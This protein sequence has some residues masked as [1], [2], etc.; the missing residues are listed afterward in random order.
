MSK[1]TTLVSKKIAKID[2]ISCNLKL[3]N[4]SLRTINNIVKR[5]SNNIANECGNYYL[6]IYETEIQHYLILKALVALATL[7]LAVSQ[8]FSSPIA[9]PEAEAQ[10]G[11]EPV[12]PVIID[13]VSSLFVKMYSSYHIAI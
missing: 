9:N 4:F 3:N 7:A 11:P 12:G 8:S 1:I 13:E 5:N 10:I 6:H 2:K